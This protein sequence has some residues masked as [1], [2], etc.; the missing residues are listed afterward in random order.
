MNAAQQAARFVSRG[1]R[2][3]GR[4]GARRRSLELRRH[5]RLLLSEPAR[6]LR[7]T[8]G[9]VAGRVML[10]RG[11][12]LFVL[13]VGAN[14]GVSDDPIHDLIV[15]HDWHGILV[16]PQPFY[17]EKLRETYASQTGIQ[18]RQCALASASGQRALYVIPPTVAEAHGQ[19]WAGGL[20]SFERQVLIGH[21]HMWPGISDHVS[22][23]EVGCATFREILQG[24]E[25]VD[26]LQIDVE[27]YDAEVVRLFDFTTWKPSIVQFEHKHLSG[28]AIDA[29]LK[30]LASFG[31]QMHM[32][33]TDVL[34]YR[35]ADEG[36]RNA[37]SGL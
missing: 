23:I 37:A 12:Q 15:A 10:D 34:A 20:A 11:E 8:I 27:G 2:Y 36:H 17:A 21:E 26:V 16:E 22:E 30:R 25:H 9:L 13:Q 3:V 31:Y 19:P 18:I 7:P 5:P 14:D 32:G 6:E 1:V 4:R 35:S 24:V 29:S 28:N 33:P